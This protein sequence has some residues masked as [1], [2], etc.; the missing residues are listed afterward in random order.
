MKSNKLIMAALLLTAFI[1]LGF[2]YCDPSSIYVNQPGDKIEYVCAPCGC[3]KDNEVFDKP[4]ACPTC[5]MPLVE[6][7]S[8][9]SQPAAPDFARKKV[10]ILIFDGVQIIDY[11]GPWEVFGQA[12][13][14][15]FT[16][17]Q[18]PDSITTAFGMKVTPTRVFADQVKPDI[19]LIPGGNV[20]AA[21]K[22][23][24]TLK[25]LQESAERAEVVLSVCNGAY[26]L[27][28]AGLL[29]GLTATTTA[30]LIDGLA[31]A[32]PNI[33]VVYDRRY[34]DNGKV[35]TTGG[36]SAGIDGALHVVARL[37][38]K[39][40]AQAI[41]LGIEYDWQPETGFARPALADKHLRFALSGLERIPLNYEGGID[42]WQSLFLIKGAPSVAEMF[43]RMNNT[44]QTEGRWTRLTAAR[45]NDTTSFWKFADADGKQWNGLL[46]IQPAIGDKDRFLMSL[47]IDR[48]AS[49]LMAAANAPD[50]NRII[51]KDAWIQEGPPSQ[52]VAA[53]FLV[54]ENQGAA[55]IAL[56]SAK[57]DAASAVELHKMESAGDV[58]KMRRLDLIPVAAGGRAELQPSGLHLMLIGLSRPL[59]Q[60]DE[61]SIT[62]QFSN[63]AQK[64]VRVPVRKRDAAAN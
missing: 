58:M 59:K 53:A 40:R 16:V 11:T 23:P 14:E 6:K 34:V 24:Q 27:A 48:D 49:K 41:A 4:G 45:A 51:I 31:Q 29:N 21:Q 30:P 56:L 10:A 39:G 33:K 20:L 5:G 28:K 36:L 62:L 52:N 61:V 9:A 60:G 17:A 1:G 25:W 42:H 44:L 26:I 18:K 38:G 12:G 54:V 55:D 57:A 35:I 47:K 46:N 63:A 2:A 50:L 7:G 64:T 37:L 13:F 3:D 32:A 22:D 43:E 15:V 8:V 19:L